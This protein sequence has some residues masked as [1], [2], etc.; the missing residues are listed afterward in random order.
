MTNTLQ[1]LIR[2]SFFNP[3]RSQ[4]D[5]LYSQALE[6]Y[7]Y[8]TPGQVVSSQVIDD[9]ESAIR[10]GH[11]HALER[12]VE[13]LTTEYTELD[14]QQIFEKLAEYADKSIQAARICSLASVGIGRFAQKIGHPDAWR[15][16]YHALKLRDSQAL[17][18]L[19]DA[20]MNDRIVIKR[21]TF[22]LIFSELA[23]GDGPTIYPALVLGA[24]LCHFD[25]NKWHGLGQKLQLYDP[26]LGFKY[27]SIVVREGP[28]KMRDDIFRFIKR[29]AKQS[30]FTS[31]E[32]LRFID[33]YRLCAPEEEKSS[34]CTIL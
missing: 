11:P 4:A 17:S 24:T 10:L 23:L 16:F 7:D 1:P 27:L 28:A 8:T 2:Y 29:A 25:L 22:F 33:K 26:N 6:I 31:E 32:A 19:L 5:S 21:S 18:N 14:N 9:L 34:P 12:L 20:I 3:A 13:V 30:L 15:Y